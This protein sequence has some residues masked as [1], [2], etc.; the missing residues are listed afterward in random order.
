MNDEANTRSVRRRSSAVPR[1]N[2]QRSSR[3]RTTW[4]SPAPRPTGADAVVRYRETRPDVTLMD[5]RLP[6]IDGIAAMAAI[7]REFADA[8]VLM[9]TTFEGDVDVQRAL[10]AGA[11]GYMLKTSAPRELLAGIRAV[12][13]GRKHIPVDDCEHAGAANRHGAVERSRDRS[14]ST[15]CR[16]PSKPGHR[17]PGSRSPKKPSKAMSGTSSTSS[18][19]RIAPKPYRSACVAGSFTCRQRLLCNGTAAL[20]ESCSRRHSSRLVPASRRSLQPPLRRSSP[21]R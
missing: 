17:R 5:L 9:L 14:A 2:R 12:H 8:R 4:R 20:S 7:R 13:S 15:A 3:T 21:S 1:R 16:G 11:R 6:D 10:A 19:R 18:E